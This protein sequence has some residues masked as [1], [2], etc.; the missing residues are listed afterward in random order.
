MVVADGLGFPLDDRAALLVPLP[1][2]LLDQPGGYPWMQGCFALSRLA[3]TRDPETGDH[4]YPALELTRLAIPR[5]V[6]TRNH[7]DYVAAALVR[8]YQRREEITRGYR[9]TYEA[10]IMR[11]FTVELEKASAGTGVRSEPQAKLIP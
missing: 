9:I 7:M 2:H 6:Y 10:P 3:E 5:R 8:I 11:H 1:Q 4:R